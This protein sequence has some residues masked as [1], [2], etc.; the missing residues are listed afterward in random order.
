MLELDDATRRA[1]S[2]RYG[3]TPD[4][5]ARVL[6]QLRGTLGGPLGPE[7]GGGGEGGLP[8]DAPSGG[9]G[10]VVWMAK[11]CAATAG[12][13]GAGLLVL[14]LGASVLLDSGERDPAPATSSDL[15]AASAPTKVETTAAA[16]IAARTP[17][18]PER[19]T[20]S[21]A[22]SSVVSPAAVPVQT[23]SA[24]PSTLAAELAL[25]DA[26]ERI[27]SSDPEAALVR[28]D[29]HQ[30]EFPTGALA[31]ER[32]VMRTEVLCALGRARAASC[33]GTGSDKSGH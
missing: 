27:R 25:L 11:I 2:Q 33:V 23:P 7:P 8:L 30:R 26:A 24:T 14:K 31:P 5:Q 28:L 4:A 18:A 17:D 29:Q 10:Q 32:E 22:P 20:D 19:Q 16:P 21:D 15:A 3:P 12:L 9:T 1:L 13:T 6:A